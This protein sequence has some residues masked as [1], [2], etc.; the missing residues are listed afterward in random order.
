M[1]CAVFNIVSLKVITEFADVA[2]GLLCNILSSSFTNLTHSFAI[3]EFVEHF[4]INILN[5]RRI[6]SGKLFQRLFRV[7]SDVCVPMALLIG[8]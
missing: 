4:L 8:T 1:S 2:H 3:N 5:I 6:D 7:D